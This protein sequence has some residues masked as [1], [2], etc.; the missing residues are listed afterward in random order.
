MGYRIASVSSSSAAR[1]DHAFEWLD[2]GYYARDSGIPLV[3]VTRYFD[4]LHGDPRWPRLIER[5]G[6]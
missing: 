6:L 4:A 1:S 2:R 5:L 3:K